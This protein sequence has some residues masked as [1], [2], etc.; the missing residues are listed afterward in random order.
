MAALG[1]RSGEARRQRRDAQEQTG[2]PVPEDLRQWT[3][4]RLVQLGGND[5][6]PAAA[7]AALRE[8]GNRA[9]APELDIGTDAVRGVSLCELLDRDRD[10]REEA[11]SALARAIDHGF[12]ADSI[13]KA[14]REQHATGGSDRRGLIEYAT[15]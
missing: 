7:V 1:R 15:Y 14:A 12:D 10:F 4:E 9:P 13:V 8:L 3:T 6:N 11:V 5:R 2:V